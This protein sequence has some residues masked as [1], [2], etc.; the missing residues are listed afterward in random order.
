LKD[1]LLDT[2]EDPEGSLHVLSQVLQARIDEGHGETLFD[3]GLEDSGEW[4][5]HVF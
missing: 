5:I 2:S 4:V 1:L 3:I